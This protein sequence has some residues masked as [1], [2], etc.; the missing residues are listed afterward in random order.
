M[1]LSF[2]RGQ[3]LLLLMDLCVKDQ[4]TPTV[5]RISSRLSTVLLLPIPGCGDLE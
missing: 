5:E 4:R 1:M 2:S 3:A